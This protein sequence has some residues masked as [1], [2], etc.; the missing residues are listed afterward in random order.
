MSQHHTVSC[1]P[2][3]CHWGFFDAGL[4]PVATLASGDTVSIY[5]VPGGPE[6]LPAG[7]RF[8]ILADHRAILEALTPKLGAHILTGPVAVT[9]AAPG[10]VLEIEILSVEPRQNWGYTRIRP[11]AGTLPEDFPIRQTIHSTIDHQRGV[12]PLPWGGEK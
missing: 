11:L 1:R 3:H 10:D 12:E 7:S 8:E 5:C 2:E 4:K 9:D 6:V